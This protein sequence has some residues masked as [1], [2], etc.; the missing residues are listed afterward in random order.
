MRAWH[1]MLILL[2][3]A[4]A[5]AAFCALV[6]RHPGVTVDK[7]LPMCAVDSHG[8]DGSDRLAAWGGAV[9]PERG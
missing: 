7:A 9:E 3:W 8:S 1:A 2:T 4:P 5:C 6:H